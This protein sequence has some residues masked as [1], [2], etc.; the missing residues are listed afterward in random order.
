MKFKDYNDSLLGFIV[1]ILTTLIT[2]F[3][4]TTV[5]NDDKSKEEIWQHLSKQIV[6][7]KTDVDILKGK[8]KMHENL[9]I[10]LLSRI[11]ILE[12]RYDNLVFFQREIKDEKPKE[13]G[14]D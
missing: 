8:M 7:I 2:V 10:I 4:V 9:P 12:T 5:T 13:K 6:V 1:G 14:D 11:E 3:I